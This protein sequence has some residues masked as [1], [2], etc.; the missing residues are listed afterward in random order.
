MS[1]VAIKFENN[2]KLLD[3]D[4][5][6]LIIKVLRRVKV[7]SILL[8]DGLTSLTSSVILEN[9][10]L[11]GIMFL[12]LP[13]IYKFCLVPSYSNIFPPNSPYHLR[14]HFIFT[15]AFANIKATLFEQTLTKLT[16]TR[17]VALPCSFV[18]TKQLNILQRVLLST[19][20]LLNFDWQTTDIKESE[21]FPLQTYHPHSQYCNM[22]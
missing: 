22:T 10:R 4:L 3:S 14:P 5:L 7:C 15:L 17:G 12:V 20:E 16:L 9:E 19:Q 18:W 1:L 8:I 11:E 6:G 21:Y 13:F 2:C